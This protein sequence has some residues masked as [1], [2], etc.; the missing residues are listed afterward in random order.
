MFL[1]K[2][3]GQHNR[4]KKQFHVKNRNNLYR[5]YS[6]LLTVTEPSYHS[7]LKGLTATKFYMRVLFN[8][9]HI[10]AKYK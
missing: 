10:S 4:C 7:M 1:I 6:H 5:F 9:L 8:I 3:Y 2:V